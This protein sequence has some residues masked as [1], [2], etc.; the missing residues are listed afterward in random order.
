MS[1]KERYRRPQTIIS[2]RLV[3]RISMS[4][5]PFAAF[6]PFALP[7][8][9]V[10]F[11]PSFY[12][13]FALTAQNPFLR[14]GAESSYG[15]QM[16]ESPD[17][18]VNH[19]APRINSAR[20]EVRVGL[21][22]WDRY[23]VVAVIGNSDLGE[24]WLCH[25]RD[26]QRDVVVRLLAQDLRRS[27]QALAVI[28]AGI[29]RLSDQ[30]H[31]SMAAIRQLVYAGDQV[32]LVGDYAPGVDLGTW[33]QRGPDGQRPLEELLPILRQVADALDFAH[34]NHIIHRNL[35]PTNILLDSD[36]SARVT[37]FGLV[38]HHHFGFQRGEADRASSSR[39]YLAPEM[40]HGREPDSASDQ[41]A[42][43]ALAWHLL[44]GAP[45]DEAK[46]PDSL[47]AYARAAFARA[48]SP[49]ARKRFVTCEDFV[50]ALGGERVGGRRGRSA[51]E[52]RRIGIITGS[53][54]GG[55][56]ATA[57]LLLGGR[58]LAAW[59]NT[60]STPRPAP[61]RPASTP[62]VVEEK[63]PEWTPPAPLVATTPLP[64]PGQPWVAHVVPMEFV[65]VSA[66]QAWVGRYEVTNEEYRRMNP[67]HTSGDYEGLCLNGDRQPVVRV[68]FDDTVAYAAW[69][70]E[71]EREA[72]KLPATLR[73][74]LPSRMEAITYT[75]S[76]LGY[77]YPWGE[78]WPPTRGNYADASLGSA[79]PEK[80]SISGYQ[81]GFAVT[82]PVERSG[83]N[84]WGLFGAG[85]N[86][87][88]TTSRGAGG[89]Q[90]GGWQGGGWED[91]QAARMRADALYGF[92]GNARGAVNGFRLVLAPIDNEVAA[93][94]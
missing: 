81:D 16:P 22:L 79:F 52:W 73:Y 88:E 44:A 26:E 11:H 53:I 1:R 42:L 20:R 10:W 62:A 77:T 32:F 64:T 9:V 34:R 3:L 90:F 85:G 78:N 13:P 14:P 69:L 76:G 4:L 51:S 2:C 68:N 35:K 28:H 83:E 38:P 63:A 93:G 6:A 24:L 67:E 33:A 55:L 36:G 74:R 27:K 56:A 15:A 75:R 66:M 18:E 46:L 58:A 12:V 94:D 92:I 41:Y 49:K 40:R 25:D 80:P 48:M 54:A 89:S 50:R 71:Q 29:R 19:D 57:V 47:P 5:R 61:P 17:H 7:G 8:G 45:P 82:A 91:Y 60:P 87:W 84:P 30:N 59:L 86:V 37:D 70:T 21:L 23:E 65:W 72:G 39:T 43:A 31:P